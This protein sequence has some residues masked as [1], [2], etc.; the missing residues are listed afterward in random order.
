MREWDT[1]GIRAQM[2][3]VA[4]LR[5][6]VAAQV[7]QRFKRI[8]NTWAARCTRL[9]KTIP[10][11]LQLNKLLPALS[12]DPLL[13]LLVSWPAPLVWRPLGF[14]RGRAWLRDR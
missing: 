9:W 7:P 6:Q 4:E 13:L 1:V 8:K 12:L 5:R 11:A 10:V 2:R 14:V 3:W